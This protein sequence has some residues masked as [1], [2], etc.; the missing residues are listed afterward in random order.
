MRSGALRPV[1]HGFAVYRDRE[2]RWTRD[3]EQ[4]QRQ[5][6]REMPGGIDEAGRSPTEAL[7]QERRQRPADGR[8]EPAPQGQR[9]DGRPR[10]LAVQPAE[11]REGGVIEAGAHGGAEHEPGQHEHPKRRRQAEQH[12]ADGEQDHRAGHDG[13]AAMFSDQPADARRHHPG[14]QKPGRQAADDPRKRPAGLGRDRGR[15]HGQEV[16]GRAPG[17]DLFDAEGRNDRPAARL[18]HAALPQQV[19]TEADA[20]V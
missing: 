1:D 16:I 20:M 9:R 5:R 8:G 19:E 17:E 7:D 4:D 10:L 2:W 18:A 6:D 14:D 11:G 15:E 13:P 3:R 12:E